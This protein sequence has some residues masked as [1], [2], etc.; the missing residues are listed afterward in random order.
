[1]AL[2]GETIAIHLINGKLQ[3]GGARLLFRG[4]EARNGVIHAIYPFLETV[5]GRQA[6][7]DTSGG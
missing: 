6:G 2:S 4:T 7:D 1:M 3:V 5:D